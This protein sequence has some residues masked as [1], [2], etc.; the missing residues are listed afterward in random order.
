MLV[1]VCALAGI[2][3]GWCAAVVAERAPQ[4]RSLLRPRPSVGLDRRGAGIVAATIGLFA[5]T[6]WRFGG[7]PWGVVVVVLVLFTGLVA[8]AVAD[9]EVQRLPDVITA[10]LY[11]FTLGGI[12]VVSLALREPERIRF[13]LLGGLVWVV[14]LGIGWLI[15]MGFGDVK[16]GGVMGLAVGWLAPTNTEVLT[17]VLYALLAGMAAA[18]AFG[19][20]D[21]VHRRLASST[22]TRERRWFALGPFLVVGAVVVILFHGALVS[23][24]PFG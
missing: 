17:L 19:V 10:P 20:V 6:G 12:V 21:L 24:A 7:A 8:L 1:L 18:S 11:L 5:L 23:P 4:R 14:C 9:I 13:A 16:A 3:A 2:P 22:E 15:G